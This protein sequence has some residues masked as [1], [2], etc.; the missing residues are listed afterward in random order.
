MA[1]SANSIKKAMKLDGPHPDGSLDMTIRLRMSAGRIMEVDGR[2]CGDFA[3]EPALAAQG[4]TETVV[5]T[6]TEFIKAAQKG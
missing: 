6:V 3:A 4:V 2:W 1:A 5:A